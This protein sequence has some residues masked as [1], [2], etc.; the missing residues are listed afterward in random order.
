[1]AAVATALNLYY[2]RP[3]ASARPLNIT[4]VAHHSEW[5]RKIYNMNNVGF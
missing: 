5:N 2:N 4:R 3:A 1:M